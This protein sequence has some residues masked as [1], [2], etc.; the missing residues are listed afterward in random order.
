MVQPK[1]SPMAL[2]GPVQELLVLQKSPECIRNICILAH[3]DHGQS[4]LSHEGVWA[5]LAL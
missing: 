3:V 5:G 4:S 1:A 2:P